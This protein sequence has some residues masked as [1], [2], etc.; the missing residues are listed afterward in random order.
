[1]E[2]L[3]ILHVIETL[4][5]EGGGGD[6]ACAE[7][8]EAQALN[9][10]EVTVLCTHNAARSTPILIEEVTVIKVAPMK[11][12]ASSKLGRKMGWNLLFRNRLLAE[13]KMIDIVHCHGT[14]RLLQV[15]VRKA[16]QASGIPYVSQP[17]G[18]FMPNHLLH[19]KW[20]KLLWGIIFERR[21]LAAA[22]ALQA[23]TQTDLNDI[24]NYYP[25]P[26]ICIIPC[27]SKPVNG[28][29][30]QAA[31]EKCFPDIGKHP[32]ILYLGRLDFQKGIDNLIMAFEQICADQPDLRLAIVGPDYNGTQHKLTQLVVERGIDRV[33]FMPIVTNNLE[34]KALFSR[35][36]C[37]VLP[38]HSENFG[39]TVLEALL[40]DCPVLVSR[41][42]GWANL[43][44]DQS[45]LVFDPS[46]AGVY[47]AMRRFFALTT[48]EQTS[49]VRQGR[50]IAAEY[51]WRTIA[52]KQ[53]LVYQ[54]ILAAQRK[55]SCV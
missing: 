36:V 15:Y 31:F 11:G 40:A 33:Y 5:V 12:L 41:S 47:N 42:T 44:L 49:M 22:A 27:G 35:A 8:A 17:H 32:Y 2:K 20:F 23:E 43:E 7:L 4:V 25:H 21:N 19:Q 39:I 52:R 1:M 37:F 45:G 24:R 29:L 53:N 3:R 38:S 9:G 18:S 54:E 46:H 13:L 34:K 14:W 48:T 10:H 30:D 16:C 50:C 55:T 26:K 51:D 6:R 28:D